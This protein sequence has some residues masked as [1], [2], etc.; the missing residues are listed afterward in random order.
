MTGT[1]FAMVRGP[2]ARALAAALRQLRKDS[3]VTLVDLAGKI[4]MS[5]SSLDRVERN[6][7]AVTPVEVAMLIGALGVTGPQVDVILQLAVEANSPNW[8]ATGSGIPLQ[9]ATV[10]DYEASAERIT[11]VTNVVM[12]GLLQ[13]DSYAREVFRGGGVPAE[14]IEARVWARRQ[15]QA[16]LTRENPVALVAIIDEP[17]VRRVVGGRQVAADQLRHIVTM[18][19]RPNVTVQVIPYS[20]GAHGATS[21]SFELIELPDQDHVVHTE[22]VY[23]GVFFDQRPPTLDILEIVARLRQSA[24]SPAES[25]GLIHDVLNS[26]E[27]T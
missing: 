22:N 10:V 5:K 7:R 9:V 4:G 23:G 16:V 15:R 18:A 24:L 25:T 20:A 14:E 19:A 3:G 11:V 12:P 1:L 6:T 27:S 13:I 26:L 2:K 8:L 17:A 21:G